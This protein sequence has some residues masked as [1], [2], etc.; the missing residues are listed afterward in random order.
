MY[1]LIAF[2]LT[3]TFALTACNSATPTQ[4]ENTEVA[5]AKVERLNAPDFREKL[6]ALAAEGKVQLI[7]VRTPQEFGAGAIEGS[8]NHN[9]YEADF[10]SQLQSYDKD[11]PVLVYC[12]SGARSAQAV[13]IF[14]SMGFKEIYELAGGYLAW[15]Q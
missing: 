4:A 5:G 7:D 6:E 1:R 8:A 2:A 15:A 9:I 11:K 12:K 3:L 10:Q 14:Q 13:S